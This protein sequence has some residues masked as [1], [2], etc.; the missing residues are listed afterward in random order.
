MAA[1]SR[2]SSPISRW[3]CADLPSC[4]KSSPWRSDAAHQA[5]IVHRDL[6]PSNILLTSDGVPK[7]ADFGLAKVIGED[8]GRTQSGQVIGTPSYM[9]PEQAEGRSKDVGPGSDV[10]A[11]GAILYETLTGRPPFLGVTQIE[12][13]RLVCSTEP[14][15]P[16]QLRPDIP[17]DLETIC[18]KCLVKE[19]RK[20]YA[21]AQ[22]LAEDL[23][24]FL[25]GL[26][27]TARP[28][29]LWERSWRLCRRNPRLAAVS[30]T[31]AA[32]MVA[33]MVQTYR[34]N[35]Q[36]Q[37]EIGRTEAKAADARRNY[38]EAGSAIEAMLG[39]LVNSRIEMVPRLMEL[40][41]D[42]REA[43]LA[44][45]ERILDK[46]ES[47]DPNDPTVRVDMIRALNQTA[48]LEYQLGRND[49]AKTHSEKALGLIEGLRT[50]PPDA[51]ELLKLEMDT[52]LK[53]SGFCLVLGQKDYAIIY[54]QRVVDAAVL[55]PHCLV[56]LPLKK[57]S[58]TV[59]VIMEILCSSFGGFRR[60]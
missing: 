7:V 15:L 6:K 51:N 57:R 20:R 31:L 14:V 32:T 13:L 17:R 35:L 11:L 46:T 58:R 9:A 25:D 40:R 47:T 16:R 24:R 21:S 50:K 23:R 30:A 22:D 39:L 1:T 37:A 49:R 41:R 44:F 42:Q 43:A 5:G 38:H 8:S 10:Y 59:T 34:H 55:C 45:Y 3:P 2:S 28:V 48:L 60:P 18:L 54:S 56:K 33:F 27:I 53:L 29:R 36:L 26:P 12:T 52:L 4:S 19:P